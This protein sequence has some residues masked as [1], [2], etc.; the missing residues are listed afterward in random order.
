MS[1]TVAIIFGAIVV[2][3]VV[4]MLVKRYDTKSVLIGAGF[5]MAIA[6]FKPLMA[7]EAF[8]TSMVSAGLIQSICSVMGF[9]L[10]MKLTQCDKHL[11]HA[12]AKVLSRIR[13][14]LIPGACAATFV[15]NISLTSA[16]G[17]SAAV[18][19]IL[20]PLLISM[21]VAP[22]TAGAAVI[23]GTFGS[24]L[25]PGL[26]HQPIIAKLANMEIIDV[27]KV[28]AVADITC[29]VV[30]A[31]SLTIVAKF[32]KEDK[33]YVDPENATADLS[34]KVNPLFA[35]LP[36]IPV[37]LLL[38]LNTD[39]ARSIFPWAAKI[40]VPHAM[41]FGAFLCMAVTMTKP[42]QATKAYFE[43]MG[44]GYGD[45]IGIIISAAIF[46]SGMKALGMIEAGIQALQ[47]TTHIIPLA[48]TYGPFLLAVVS[49]SG[50][51]A[52]IAF[53][54]SVTVH[55]ETFGFEIANMGALAGLSGALGRGMSPIAGATIICATL[56]KVN[57]FEIAKRNA[58]GMI[59][60][61]V[62]AMVILMYL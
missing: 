59:L 30:A 43:G 1:G 28:H 50:D 4:Y 48:T 11:I 47:Q 17:V 12:L 10:V 36:L 8:S 24:M 27:I 19:A 56:A 29:L 25:S 33:G 13:P 16:A 58:L 2:I 62:A 53:N 7:F 34:F 42:V 52:A 14:V 39:F 57:P 15:V 46:V 37:A 18:G 54:E 3:G 60:A 26:S 9:A 38:F 22:A 61:S 40:K 21:G 51:A 45:I 5:L 23:V 6:S 32:L 31:I 44:K 35:I 20:I 55:A 41:L 49:G